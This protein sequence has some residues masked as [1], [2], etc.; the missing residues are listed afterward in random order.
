MV[1]TTLLSYDLKKVDYS[2]TICMR[3]ATALVSTSSLWVGLH[4]PI[5]SLAHAAS[6][7]VSAMFTGRTHTSF[8]RL[9][10]NGIIQE[11][12]GAV[13]ILPSPGSA[14]AID[15]LSSR[16]LPPVPLP[17][18]PPHPPFST[19]QLGVDRRLILNRKRQLKMYR[20]WIQGKFLML[21]PGGP[22]VERVEDST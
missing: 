3:E 13:L 18:C 15:P 21:S 12:D 10:A 11:G 22:T 9:A 1:A 5:M 7:E 16:W 8:N 20:V 17:N 19:E 6:D 4:F 14:E 2:T